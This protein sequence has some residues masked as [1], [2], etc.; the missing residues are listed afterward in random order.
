LELQLSKTQLKEEQEIAVSEIA[1]SLELS[2]EEET[3][4]VQAVTS[5]MS[6]SVFM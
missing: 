3:Q 5:L 4:K 1:N 2:L 6:T